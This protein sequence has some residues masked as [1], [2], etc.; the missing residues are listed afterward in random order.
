MGDH[1][2]AGKPLQ[3][4]TS[5]S[6]QFSLLPQRDGKWVLTKVQWCSAALWVWFIPLVD[7]RVGGRQNC[8]IPRQHVP[9]LS[10]LVELSCWQ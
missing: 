10:A 2:Q 6:G 7:K 5:H 3:F 4:V 1:L 9:Y 8:V